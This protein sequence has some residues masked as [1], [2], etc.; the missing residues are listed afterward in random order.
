[1]A[2]WGAGRFGGG[3]K[4]GRGSGEEGVGA[5]EGVVGD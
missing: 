5:G 1:M 4:G 3:A 2:V